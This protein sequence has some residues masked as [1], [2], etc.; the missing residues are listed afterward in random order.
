MYICIYRYV[1]MY[2]YI[3]IYREREAPILRKEVTELLTKRNLTTNNQ[4]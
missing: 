1:Y 3:Y 4:V 2:I